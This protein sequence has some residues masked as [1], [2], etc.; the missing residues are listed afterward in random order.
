MQHG[1][2]DINSRWQALVAGVNLIIN[3]NTMHQ[4]SAM[5]MLSPEGISHTFDDRANGYGRGEGIGS[6]IVK[7]L[8]DALRDGD[9]IR[10]VIRGTG[11]N[12]DGRT[13]SITQPSTLAQ[14]NLI[15][16]TYEAAGLSQTSTQYFESHGTGTPVGVSFLYNSLSKRLTHMSQ[17]P[18]ELEAI[19]SSLGASRTAAG[20]SPLYVGSIKPNVGHT[21]GCS[22]LAG[23][24]KA[25]VCLEKGMLVPTYGVERLNP[26][27]KLADWNLALP[28]NTMKWPNRG[29]RRASINSFGFG[30]ANA[31]AILDD[32]YHYLSDRGLVGNHNTTV[33]EDDGG[34]DSGVSTG[35][36]TPVL[37]DEK[38]ATFLFVFSTKDQAGIQR[39]AASYADTLQK[40]GLHKADPHYLS[41]LAYTLSE[42]RSHFD[43]RSLFVASNLA[44]LGAQLSKGLP[45]TKRS[46]RQDNNL[47]FVFTGQGAQ[48]PAMGLQLLSNAVFYKSMRTSQDYLKELGCEWDAFEEL[49]K[50]ADSNINFPQYS[51]TL[52]TVLQVALVDLLRYWKVTPKATIGHSSGEIGKLTYALITPGCRFVNP[53]KP[54][55][56]P[57][58]ISPTRTPSR[59][60]TSGVSALPL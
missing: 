32:A 37:N 50:T 23:V 60:P 42:R 34:S 15:K 3:P 18:I 21:E 11:A 24:F 41:N 55:L 35:P 27:L 36:G 51:Q 4:F 13:P 14:A 59:L 16:R 53:F 39:L 8:S 6:L 31:H 9:T 43:F 44:E 12:A 2:P 30:G 54:R 7:R 5:H 57:H 26:K 28:Q 1:F 46:S 56:M 20:L 38:N 22:G 25:L 10:A 29:Q 45:K 17:D 47:V 58:P 40:I 48:W 33:F 19:A 49:E 52:C